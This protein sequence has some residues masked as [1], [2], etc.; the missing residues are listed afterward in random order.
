VPG[1]HGFC[2]SDRLIGKML[3]YLRGGTALDTVMD[4][5]RYWTGKADVGA[6]CVMAD[7]AEYC[8]T[9][10]YYY[11][12][13][14]SDYSRSFEIDPEAPKRL[15]AFLR[16][17]LKL[18]ET[19]T[20]KEACESIE[21]VE[22][23]FFVEDRFAWHRTYADAWGGTPEAR[24]WEPVM[25]AMRKEYKEHCQPIV[26]DPANIDKFRELVERFW[27][28]MTNSANS[29]GRWPPPPNVT[30]AF[31]R[32]WVQDEIDATQKVLAELREAT[33][34]YSLPEKPEVT[35]PGRGNP[36]YGYHFTDKDPEDLRN[37]NTYEL[38]HAIYYAHKMVDC[39]KEPWHSRGTALLTAVFDE[40]DRRGMEGVRPAS[41]RDAD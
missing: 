11:V 15:D 5:I 36:D 10:G 9:A 13:Y 18:G 38:Q 37:L 21:P 23:P 7:D 2:R 8:G 20:F 19:I 30:C 31:N 41:I 4:N 17:I 28:H 14:E 34:G 3:Q 33:Q 24:A 35:V 39:P 25:N 1:L 40:L 29:D 27:F 12:K 16:E 32:Q 26:E 22:E 6:L